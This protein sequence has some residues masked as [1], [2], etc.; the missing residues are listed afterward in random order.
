[1]IILKATCLI[2]LLGCNN[3]WFQLKQGPKQARS[4]KNLVKFGPAV[5]RYDRIKIHR[6]AYID[7]YV[8]I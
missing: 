7:M 3:F 1:M 8:D 5:L 6:Y 2:Q 4:M